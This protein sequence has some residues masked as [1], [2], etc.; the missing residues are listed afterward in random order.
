MCLQSAWSELVS[1]GWLTNQTRMWLA[2]HWNVREGVVVLV[3]AGEKPGGE[4]LVAA[5]ARDGVVGQAGERNHNVDNLI[6]VAL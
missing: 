5:L 2:S 1:E 4:A 6:E 3:D